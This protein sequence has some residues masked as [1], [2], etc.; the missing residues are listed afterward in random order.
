[1]NEKVTNNDNSTN[2]KSTINNNANEKTSWFQRHHLYQ[3]IK[4]IVDE[5]K[6]NT[7]SEIFTKCRGSRRLVLLVVFI[8]LLFDNMLLTTVGKNQTLKRLYNLF[9]FKLKMKLQFR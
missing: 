4:E 9:F 2:E 1:M 5:I 3:D 7:W 8:A 6:D